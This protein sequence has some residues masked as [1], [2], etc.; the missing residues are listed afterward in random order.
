MRRSAS[1]VIR[2]LEG[3]IARL[4]NST[5]RTKSAST[6]KLSNGRAIIMVEDRQFKDDTINICLMHTN[7]MILRN[8]VSHIKSRLGTPTPNSLEIVEDYFVSEE[9][10]GYI[11][12]TVKLVDS[13]FWGLNGEDMSDIAQNWIN[14]N[15]LN[16]PNSIPAK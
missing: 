10:K 8:S 7:P 1:E 12:I 9:C 11:C 6:A 15:I 16:P 5:S 2:N 14:E 4:E 3:R 13:S